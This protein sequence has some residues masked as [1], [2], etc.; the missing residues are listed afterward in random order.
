[1][2]HCSI[3]WFGIRSTLRSICSRYL[4]F[5]LSQQQDSDFLEFNDQVAQSCTSCVNLEIC[6][7]KSVN[8]C[9]KIEIFF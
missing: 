2:Q 5:L 4:S 9:T 1:M 3:Y 7:Q 6:G 8:H